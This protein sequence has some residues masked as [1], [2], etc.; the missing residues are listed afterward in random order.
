MFRASERPPEKEQIICTEKINQKSSNSRSQMSQKWSQNRPT[1][2][3]HRSKM[4][5]KSV[6]NRLKSV[7]EAVLEGSGPSC[8]QEPNSAFVPPLLGSKMETKIHQKSFPNRSINSSFFA[9][10]FEWLLERFW[11]LFWRV[12]ALKLGPWWPK[13]RS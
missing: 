9:S 12:L 6:Q 7:P 2:V 10:I 11:V 1:S 8:P 3:Q 4:E 13:F 5:P